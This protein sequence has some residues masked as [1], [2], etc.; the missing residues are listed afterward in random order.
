MAHLQLATQR[1]VAHFARDSLC[2]ERRAALQ[3]LVDEGML[4]QL[5]HVVAS[6]SRGTQFGVFRNI[7]IQRLEIL[8]ESRFIPYDGSIDQALVAF[9]KHH[10]NGP[11]SDRVRPRDT[12]PNVERRDVRF[13]ETS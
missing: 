4:E 7:Q 11:L 5:V 8:K 2:F 10:P 12:G 6:T 13:V 3:L 9:P 1:L